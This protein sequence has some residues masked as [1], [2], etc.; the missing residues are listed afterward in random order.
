[1][2]YPEEE[3][4][5][6]HTDG[7]VVPG[8]RRGGV[9]A[10]F[11]LLDSDGEE[12]IYEPSTAGYMGATNN[13][14]ELQACVEALCLATAQNPRFDPRRYRNIIIFSDS[15]C[16]EIEAP[17]TFLGFGVVAFRVRPVALSKVAKHRG[18]SGPL[19]LKLGRPVD[20][21]TGAFHYGRRA[22][23]NPYEKN[24]SVLLQMA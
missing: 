10:I 2:E 13:Q 16:S 15:L 5:N 23:P 12:E 17:P 8:P 20:Q 18:G 19:V 6:V 11:I 14:M 4:L 21:G 24:D 7:S 22:Y 9:G 3:A 1:L